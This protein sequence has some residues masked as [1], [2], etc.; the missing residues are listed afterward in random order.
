MKKS[1]G[2]GKKRGIL[3]DVLSHS[4]SVFLPFWELL[5]QAG[6]WGRQLLDDLGIVEE[7]SLSSNIRLY[8]VCASK[9]RLNQ[10]T[11]SYN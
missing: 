3:T 6:G 2:N 9:S 8:G 4:V 10:Q 7:Y 11:G 5:D 1:M